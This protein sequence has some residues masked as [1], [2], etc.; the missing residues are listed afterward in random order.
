MKLKINIENV[1][2]LVTQAYIQHAITAFGDAGKQG[3]TSLLNAVKL[4]YQ[5]V[6]P[7]KLSSTLTVVFGLHSTPAAPAIS[8]IGEP[9]SCRDFEAVGKFIAAASVDGHLFVEIV[10]DGTYRLL[11]LTSDIDLPSLAQTALIYRLRETPSGFLLESSM[12][13]YPL[14]HPCSSATFHAHPSQS[15]GGTIILLGLRRGD[16]MPHPEENLGGWSRWSTSRA[17]Q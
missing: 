1:Q 13:T 17:R 4:I 8:S 10:Q 12:T 5:R 9:T 11:H 2:A 14:F 15:R 6:P 16:S 3:I 7:E